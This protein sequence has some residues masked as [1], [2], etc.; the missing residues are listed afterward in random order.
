[1]DRWFAECRPCAWQTDHDTQDEAIRAA[2]DHVFANHRDTP[3]QKRAVDGI[4]HVQNRTMGAVQDQPAGSTSE[5]GNLDPQPGGPFVPA[6][7]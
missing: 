7:G 6:V 1:M 2:E 3:P 4:G 5:A